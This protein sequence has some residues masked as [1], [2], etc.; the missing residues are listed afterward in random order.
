MQSEYDVSFFNSIGMRKGVDFWD[1]SSDNSCGI[2]SGIHIFIQ[3]NFSENAT[4]SLA[5]I[6]F[7]LSLYIFS[8]SEDGRKF[9]TV[10]LFGFPILPW[11]LYMER[12]ILS[13]VKS[14][15]KKWKSLD[16][17]FILISCVLTLKSKLSPFIFPSLPLVRL[18]TIFSSEYLPNSSVKYFFEPVDSVMWALFS[19]WSNCKKR[20]IIYLIDILYHFN[21]KHF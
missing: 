14:D 11:S 7:K 13:G 8:S 3:E 15:A 20:C 5:R 18:C 12:F 17:T 21:G 16:F 4:I 9:S 10:T 19:L 2:W 1:I 6:Y